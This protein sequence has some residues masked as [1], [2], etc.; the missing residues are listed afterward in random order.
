VRAHVLSWYGAR[1]DYIVGSQIFERLMH[2]PV[3]FTERASVA[4]QIARIKAF[5]AVRAFFTGT[6]FIAMAELPFTLI[7]IGAI[8]IIAGPIALVPVIAAAFYLLLIYIMRPHV[9]TAMRLAAKSHAAKQEMIIETFEKMDGLRVGG[10]TSIWFR[11]FRDLSG[12]AS[13]SGFR[14]SFLSSLL[15]VFSQGIYTLAGLSVVVW[16]V[17]HIWEGG[18]SAGALIAVMILTWRVLGP[19]QILANALPRFEQLKNAVGQI[20]RLMDIE[21]ESTDA[22][23]TA[24]LDQPKGTLDFQKVGLRYTKDND[25]VFAGLTFKVKPG[26]MMALT[27]GNGSGKSTILKLIN[28]LYHPQAGAL[29]IDG[30]DIRQL[31]PQHLR[32]HVTYVPQNPVV[33]QGTIADN[34]RFANPLASDE[35]LQNALER[36]DLQSY[37]KNLPLGMH[38]VIGMHGAAQLPTGLAYNLNLARAYVKDTSVML[39]D[40][41]PYAFLNSVSGERFKNILKSWKGKK[42]VVFVTH[43]EDYITLA[44]K[45]VL[46]RAGRSAQVGKPEDIIRSIYDS[47]EAVYA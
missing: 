44:D 7:L 37:V 38:T 43:R 10:L 6:S 1:L 22:K 31:D 28:G 42:T 36:V 27:G 2:L 20:N 30:I 5:D 9:R 39:I 47:Q 3:L 15:E 18:M 11:D 33:F 8:V 40:E 19:M 46:L 21:G 34:L 13:L 29:H 35:L 25:P 12:K 16:G 26:E 17:I 45:A 14:S 4:A 24:R 23:V 32:R 41:M